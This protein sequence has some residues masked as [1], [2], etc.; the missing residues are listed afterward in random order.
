MSRRPIGTYANS[1][2]IVC[3]WRKR[4][5]LVGHVIT[6][7]RACC[8]PSR[9]VTLYFSDGP[10][11]AYRSAPF[12]TGECWWRRSPS[13][14]RKYELS[15]GRGAASGPPTIPSHGC[16]HVEPSQAELL[17]KWAGNFDVMVIVMKKTR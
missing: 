8:G 17:F 7:G 4:W 1:R 15:Q 3:G 5:S 10:V 13:T 9:G 14:T 11:K 12:S 16:I 6:F 2:I